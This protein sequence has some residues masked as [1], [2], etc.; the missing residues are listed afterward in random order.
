MSLIQAVEEAL[1]EAGISHKAFCLSTG[2][3]PAHWTRMRKGEL[4]WPLWKMDELPAAF[5][6]AL[7][8]RLHEAHDE[9]AVRKQQLKRAFH[10]LIDLMEME[11]PDERP[12]M[13]KADLAA[14]HA[15]R[16]TA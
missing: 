12:R 15:E 5:L 16:K 14:E 9:K 1:A 4:G 7:G 2:I 6:A 3:D 10:T 13:L 11:L 8:R